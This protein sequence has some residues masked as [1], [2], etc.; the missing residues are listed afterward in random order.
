MAAT[1]H[2]GSL[3]KHLRRL[4]DPPGQTH[5]KSTVF[6]VF[7]SVTW[8]RHIASV[9]TLDI[10]LVSVCEIYMRK[11]T[12]FFNYLEGAKFGRFTYFDIFGA[13]ALRGDPSRSGFF[14]DGVGKKNPAWPERH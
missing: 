11:N 4:P 5:Q 12:L 6:S 3:K 13:F 2:V 10:S 14:E 9:L 1:P 7:F 8:V